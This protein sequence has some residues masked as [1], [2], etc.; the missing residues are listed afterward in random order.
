MGFIA[1][2]YG[3][4]FCEG[5]SDL[6]PYYWIYW[7][8]GKALLRKG[9]PDLLYRRWIDT[10]GGE[11]FGR[12]VRDVLALTDRVGRGLGPA[13]RQAMVERFVTMSRYEVMFWD[14]G[15]REGTWPV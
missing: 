14:I 2:V 12:I 11:Q 8:V 3:R 6:L 13:D 7:E 9:S 10:Y 5:P 4:P 15:Y 1:V